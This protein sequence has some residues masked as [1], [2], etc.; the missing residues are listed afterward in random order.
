MSAKN[1]TYWTELLL[2]EMIARTIKNELAYITR[3]HMKTQRMPGDQSVKK[4]TA[5]FLNEVFGEGKEGIFLKYF[6]K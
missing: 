6:F 1:S 4:V 2:I 5:E 3:S